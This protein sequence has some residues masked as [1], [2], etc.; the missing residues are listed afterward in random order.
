MI[1]GN[2]NKFKGTGFVC[3]ID[4]LG[5]S[6]DI[7]TNWNNPVSNPLEKILSIKRNMPVNTDV[8]GDDG[9][10]THRTYVCRVNTISDSVTICFG[11]N[12]NN[13]IGDLILGLEAVLGDISYIWST[14]IHG[15][16]T[17]RGAI[18]FG[19]IYWDENELIGP[20]FINVY[21]LESDVVKNSRVIVSSKLNKLLKNIVTLH[22]STLLTDHLMQNFKKD[23]DGYLIVDPKII[24][25]SDS[26]RIV[27]IER[28]KKIR[29]AIPSGIIRE[30]YN[31]LINMLSDE[32]RVALKDEE[33]G[34][35]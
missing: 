35:Y 14:C 19:D 21:R 13:M 33:I 34:N 5:F 32:A 17:I 20:A 6:N 30:K 1:L 7:L 31:P 25:H 26:E 8:L 15:G 18:D 24:Y 22:K 28:L 4:V 16:Y 3:F 11:F 10:E 29:D 9:R 12:Q 2:C 23:I 27:L